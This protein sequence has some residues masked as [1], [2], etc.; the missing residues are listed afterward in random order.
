MLENNNLL[1][2]I[3]TASIELA[4]NLKIITV[5]YKSIQFIRLQK[6]EWNI[7]LLYYSY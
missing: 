1:D 2:H 3:L 5:H 4:L 7:E 6:N